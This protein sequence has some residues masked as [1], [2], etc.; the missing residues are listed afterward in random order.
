MKFGIQMGHN[1]KSVTSD[2]FDA[3][4]PKPVILSPRNVR[5]PAGHQNAEDYLARDA[6]QLRYHRKGSEKTNDIYI[7]PQ[8]FSVSRPS[9]QIA[10]FKYWNT[11]NEDL[12]TNYED[13]VEH[14]IT[15]N[16]M[17]GTSGIILPGSTTAQINQDWMN[18][19]HRI[20]DTAHNK[21]NKENLQPEKPLF[22]TVAL[23]AD[24]IKD[25]NA[26]DNMVNAIEGWDVK[27]IYL[28]CEHPNNAYLTDQ[29]LWLLNLMNLVAG[30]KR[31]H[32]TV[33][34]GYASHQM[35]IL[36]L[37]KCD[38]LFAGNFL[39]VRRFDTSTFEDKDN[40]K[41]SRRS[42]WYYA[43]QTLSEFKV[44]TLDLV[45][46][47]SNA[48]SLLSLLDSPYPEDTFIR[49]LFGK[50]MPSDTAYNESSSFK[51]YLLCLSKQCEEMTLGSYNQTFDSYNLR[52][53]TAESAISGLREYGIYD[54]DR[55]YAYSLPATYQALAAFDKGMGEAMRFSWNT[56]H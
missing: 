25:A 10:R 12:A 37:A 42:T 31:A 55:N 27:G 33:F 52:L 26:I 11:N 19:E 49:E 8:L 56:I 50:A 44:I 20:I 46:Q 5:V 43:P 41:P 30:I 36:A 6:S 18:L 45:R 1:M 15:L 24:V 4:G 40:D 39:N 32:K 35:L 53:K 14:L 38:Y 48:D 22:A 13:T 9:K 3:I 16:Q 17:C 21:S 28:V 54:P 7:D 51:H 2:L 47:S 34:V 29:P 23:K